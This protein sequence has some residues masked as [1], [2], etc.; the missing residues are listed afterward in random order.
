MDEWL[1][2]E[3]VGGHMGEWVDEWVSNEGWVECAYTQSSILM[4][5]DI[6]RDKNHTN[7]HNHTLS[8]SDDMLVAQP[9]LHQALF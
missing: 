8:F 9:P 3:W 7:T 2:G 5:T 4:Y 6:P 1:V